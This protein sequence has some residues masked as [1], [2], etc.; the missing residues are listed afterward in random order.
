MNKVKTKLITWGIIFAAA[1]LSPVVFPPTAVLA[2]ETGQAAAPGG[3]IGPGFAKP[4][5]PAP[6]PPAVG[7]GVEPFLSEPASDPSEMIGDIRNLEPDS[8]I[9]PLMDKYSY[10]QMTHDITNL[11][12]V[13]GNLMSVNV[14]GQSLDNRDIYE[15]VIGNPDSDKHILIQ[16]G[17]HAREQL[18][19]LL[20]MKQLE[21]ALYSC[22]RGSYNGRPVSELLNHAALHFIPMSNPDGIALS[23]FGMSAIRSEELRDN[24]LHCYENDLCMGRT[25]SGLEQYLIHWKANARGVDLNN[26]FDAGWEQMEQLEAPSYAGYKGTAPFTEPETQALLNLVNQREWAATVSY[27]AMGNLIY[28]DFPVNGQRDSSRHLGNLMAAATGYRMSLSP[29]SYGGF[30]DWMQSSEHSAPSVTLEVGIGTCPLPI[31]DF[32]V[33][34]SQN[35]TVWAVALEFVLPQ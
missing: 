31:S 9:I 21:L 5:E 19:P 6:A 29:D 18:P 17:I 30:K 16:A 2:D 7:P 25:S 10:E 8:P 32:L 20:V 3:E 34:W 28:W 4:A 12:E 27:H 15:V 11:S 35:K 33:I 13:Y 24:I 14:I 1:I 22:R 26:N 23:Q